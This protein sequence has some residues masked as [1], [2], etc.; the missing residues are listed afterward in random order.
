MTWEKFIMIY[1]YPHIAYSGKTEIIISAEGH[2]TDIEK[3]LII[4]FNLHHKMKKSDAIREPGHIISES[5][6]N[7]FID[8]DHNEIIECP[9]CGNHINEDDPESM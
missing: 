1:L 9:A 4:E 2:L 6:I 7:R 8:M 3:G 5:D